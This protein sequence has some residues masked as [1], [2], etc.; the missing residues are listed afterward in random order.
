M[1]SPARIV[2]A[3]RQRRRELGL[4]HKEVAKRIGVA[5]RTVVAW[6]SGDR[7]P[8]IHMIER[9][10]EALGTAVT[11]GPCLPDSQALD[12]SIAVER[13][14]RGETPWRLLTE[15]QRLEVFN[16]LRARDWSLRRIGTHLHV[17]GATVAALQ[18]GRAPR[19]NGVAA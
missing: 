10:A 19:Q 3:L 14:I 2:A 5:R 1:A 16:R 9:Y 7:S 4:Y 13:A 15:P 11:L 8:D 18:S 6:E 17:N 12:N